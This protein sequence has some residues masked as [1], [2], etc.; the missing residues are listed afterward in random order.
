MKHLPD[1][2][3]F[4]L[5]SLFY[6][7]VPSILQETGKASP[8]PCLA[9]QLTAGPSHHENLLVLAKRMLKCSRVL[10]RL[11]LRLP[12]LPLLII[13]SFLSKRGRADASADDL[14]Q[15]ANDKDPRHTARVLYNVPHVPF[16]K[17]CSIDICLAP[18]PWC[19]CLIN[20]HKIV[21]SRLKGHE[22]RHS[23][24]PASGKLW[25]A[26]LALQHHWSHPRDGQAC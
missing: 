15:H 6:E 5:V 11:M 22:G 14:M 13:H 24:K 21:Q 1:D 12:H 25:H 19:F 4:R 3:M 9:V 7:V 10:E 8:F 16:Q 18:G 23:R 17:A 26:L 2:P 20:T